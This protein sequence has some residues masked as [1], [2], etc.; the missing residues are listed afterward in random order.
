MNATLPANDS[1]G[2][3]STVAST[4]CPTRT[5]PTW[6][7][8]TWALTQTRCRSATSNIGWPS[9]TYCPSTMF[10]FRTPPADLRDDRDRHV[11]LALL[12]DLVDLRLGDPPELELLGRQTH[13]LIR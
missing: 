3:A 4:S 6:S 10:F 7:S 5:S 8:K 13:H 1:P 9:E 11:G 12:Q 2:N